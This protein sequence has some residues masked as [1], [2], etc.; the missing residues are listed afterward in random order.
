MSHDHRCSDRSARARRRGRD[1]RR[2]GRAGRRRHGDRWTPTPS[3][4]P[5]CCCAGCSDELA[6]AEPELIAA[7]QARRRQLAGPRARVGRGQ[8]AGRGAALPP[9]SC[10]RPATSTAAPATDRVRAERDRRAGVR[11]VAQWANDNT[12]DLRSLAGQV[13]AADR[14]R[15]DAATA[16]LAGST[17]PSPTPTRPRCPRCSPPSGSTSAATRRW[18]GGSTRS[19]PAPTRCSGTPSN[20]ATASKPVPGCR[21]PRQ[22]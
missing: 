21:G 20:A 1:R 3:S 13:T 16:D 19:P 14:S 6:A 7:A 10:R 15:P 22:H 5:W 18:R 4:T 9:S 8:P 2:G 11:A 17:T 12:A